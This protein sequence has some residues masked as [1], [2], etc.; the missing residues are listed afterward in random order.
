MEY[1]GDKKSMKEIT[2]L[3]A[4]GMLGSAVTKHFIS[5]GYRVKALVRNTELAKEL[6]PTASVYYF[7]P[8]ESQVFSLKLSETVFNA[9]GIIKPRFTSNKIADHIKINSIFPLEMAEFCKKM[10]VKFI[11]P[12]TDCVFSPESERPL[13]EEHYTDAWDLYGKSKALGEPINDAMVLR[14]SIIG[15]ETGSKYSLIEWCKSKA[16]QEV[17]G[18]MNHDWNGITTKQYGKILQQIIEDNLYTPGLFHIVPPD[19]VT[20]AVLLDM[21]DTKFNLGLI[22]HYVDA[23]EPSCRILETNQKLSSKLNIPTIKD[24]VNDL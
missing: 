9:I 12:S 3:G 17:D 24:M 22:I 10:D 7:D 14:V 13:V 5:Q 20:K 19:W 21:I 15:E 4:T 8:L 2:I 6:F 18:Y 23:K 1:L 11:H 16:G